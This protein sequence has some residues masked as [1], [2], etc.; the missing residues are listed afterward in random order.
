M[1][2]DVFL[3]CPVRDA[4]TEQ[5]E[6]MS[7]YIT[8]LEKAGKKVYYPAHDTNQID[9]VG[10]RICSDNRDA[11]ISSKEI[12]I[13]WDKNSQGSLFDLGMAFALDKPLFIVNKDMGIK[14]EAKSFSNMILAWEGK[15]IKGV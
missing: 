5:K 10:F 6:A 7:A 2:Y 13:F 1:K 11:I 14:T 8:K 3:I 12:H 4:T 15:A 9:N